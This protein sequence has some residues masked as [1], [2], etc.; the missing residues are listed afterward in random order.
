[1]VSVEA[2]EQECARIVREGYS[3]ENEEY[4]VGLIA[5]AV[6]VMNAASAVVGGLA[7][8]APTARLSLSMAVSHLPELR[9]AAK[10][11]GSTLTD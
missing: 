2:L 9:E 6:P 8:H 3:T 4:Q 5:I 11:L 7:C 1:M 10:R